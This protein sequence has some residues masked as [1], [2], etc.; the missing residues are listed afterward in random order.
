MYFI[1]LFLCILLLY[2]ITILDKK[3]SKK[4][5]SYE[6]KKWDLWMVY[7][8]KGRSRIYLIFGILSLIPGLNEFI[9]VLS[10]LAL[11]TW[12]VINIA[13]KFDL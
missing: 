6:P 1:V 9:L 4:N 11:I 5:N 13:N 3:W 7:Y 8:K 12:I 10:V 2:L